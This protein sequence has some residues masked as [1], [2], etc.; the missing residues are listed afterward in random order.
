MDRAIR[1][2]RDKYREIRRTPPRI[3]ISVFKAALAYII[4]V[5]LAMS[6]RVRS[7]FSYPIV[8]TSATVVVV[9]GYPGANIG[10]CI[11]GALLCSCSQT[12]CAELP[13]ELNRCLHYSRDIRPGR[14]GTGFSS[15]RYTCKTGTRSCSPRHSLRNHRLPLLPAKSQVNEVLRHRL[16][17]YSCIFCGYLHCRRYFFFN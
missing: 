12:C 7:G 8:L 1:R 14:C 17:W 2:V 16:A 5:I 15:L 4:L 11:G 9:A 6:G 10:Q 13:A 3:W